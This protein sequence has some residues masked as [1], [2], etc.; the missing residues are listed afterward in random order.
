[1]SEVTSQF[2]KVLASS[3]EP[4]SLLTTRLAGTPTDSLSFIAASSLIGIGNIP[5]FMSGVM[6]STRVCAQLPSC[7]IAVSPLAN[8]AR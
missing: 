7:I 8:I 3:F 1:M 2:R 6:P 5:M 4:E